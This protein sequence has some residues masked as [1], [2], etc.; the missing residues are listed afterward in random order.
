MDP[1]QKIIFSTQT[2]FGNL[3]SSS[4]FHLAR[5][6][7]FFA[8]FTSGVY[9]SGSA[10]SELSFSKISGIFSS[11][12]PSTKLSLTFTDCR[13]FSFSCYST[14][15]TPDGFDSPFILQNQKV[16][17]AEQNQRFRHLARNRNSCNSDLL[18]QKIII[19]P[20]SELVSFWINIHSENQ[21][22][23]QLIPLPKIFSK[24]TQ[25]T[26]ILSMIVFIFLN[27]RSFLHLWGKPT[28]LN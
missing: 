5:E 22:I 3:P 8:S 2:K 23:I 6:I 26:L 4:D 27:T 10:S 19:V 9:T 14:P 20:P 15:P 21:I 13:L 12:P 28:F 11:K 7:Y 24:K 1:N 16:H 18:H 25:N 17:R